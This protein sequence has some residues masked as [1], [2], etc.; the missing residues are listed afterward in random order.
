MRVLFYITAFVMVL[1]SPAW[2]V[3]P[4]ERLDDPLLESQAREI[5]KQLRCL[6]CQNQSIDE[7]DADLAKDLRILVRERL[8]EGDTPEGVIDYVTNLYGE[9]V[10]LKP[11]L[12]AHT[13]ILWASPLLFFLFAVILARRV[14]ATKP[15]PVPAEP[16]NESPRLSHT[17]SQ[18]LDQLRGK[19]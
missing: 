9:Y 15:Q 11:R 18:A 8:L 1:L 19:D 4:D 2:S 3:T 12:G 10:L 13:V 17:Q 7:S 6:V 16:A 14:F 5:S